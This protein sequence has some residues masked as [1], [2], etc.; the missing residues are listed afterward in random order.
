MAT[1]PIQII[2]A[3]TG[4]C[5]PP[6]AGIP[7]AE[8]AAISDAFQ[9]FAHPV[10]VQIVTL[11]ARSEDAVCVC[12]L[13]QAVPVKQPTVSYHLKVLREAGLVTVERHGSWAYYRLNRTE[14]ATRQAQLQ[15]QLASWL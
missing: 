3:L 6:G 9:L 7:A 4:C 5:T 11:L 2:A 10:R 13:E 1:N 14:L 12:D 15:A 8:A